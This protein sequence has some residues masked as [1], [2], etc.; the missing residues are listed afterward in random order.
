LAPVQLL[1]L[2]HLSLVMASSG[3]TLTALLQEGLKAEK[4]KWQKFETMLLGTMEESFRSQ[5]EEQAR[6]LKNELVYSVTSDLIPLAGRPS[7]QSFPND[8]V[9]WSCLGSTLGIS[10]DVK[11]VTYNVGTMQDEYRGKDANISWTI[12]GSCIAPKLAMRL[13]K[14]RVDSVNFDKDS[15]T[16]TWRWPSDPPAKRLRAPDGNIHRECKICHEIRNLHA[17]MPCGHLACAGCLA[18]AKCGSGRAPECSFCKVAI[19]HT[20]ILFEP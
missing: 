7:M 20:Q 15:V 2:F 19:W 6:R 4:D 8:H 13:G 1:L 18:K 12:F 5:C 10:S 9:A 17:A 16:A 14:L 11:S 3:E